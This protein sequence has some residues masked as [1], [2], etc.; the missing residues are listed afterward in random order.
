ML[1]RGVRLTIA[2]LALCFASSAGAQE[3]VERG[4]QLYASECLRCHDLP[5]SVTTFHG[6]VDL[7]TFL[8]EQHY[9][10]TPE[11]AAA[12]AAYL[13]TLEQRPLP[14]RRPRHT[15]RHRSEEER[16]SEPTPNTQSF[17]DPAVQ[18]PAQDPV[19]RALNA[20]F[21]GIKPKQ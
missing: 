6:G 12:I 10:D 8:G 9:A 15:R 1:S 4:K 14:R 3:K 11:S 2:S 5:Q 20:L 19:T 17:A 21:H 16:P 7:E 13:K 18:P